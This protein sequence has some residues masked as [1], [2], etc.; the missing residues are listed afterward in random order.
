MPIELYNMFVEREELVMETITKKE[1]VE[2]RVKKDVTVYKTVDGKEYKN[3]KAAENHEALLKKYPKLSTCDV[4]WIENFKCQESYTY[5]P[6][7]LEEFEQ[8]L[9]SDEAVILISHSGGDDL[10][11]ETVEP[12]L[13]TIKG[14][15]KVLHRKTIGCGCNQYVDS[16]I[17]KGESLC[18]DDEKR[19]DG[20]YYQT[21]TGRNIKEVFGGI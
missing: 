1:D 13:K 18:F 2:V 4:D 6:E 9:D 15:I 3:K 11:F 7:T 10:Q 20:T 14:A 17:Y 5:D 21:G 19:D 16:V 8:A 12:H